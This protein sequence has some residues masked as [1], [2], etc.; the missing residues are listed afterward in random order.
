MIQ[1]IDKG[2][3]KNNEIPI[4]IYNKTTWNNFMDDLIFYKIIIIFTS[5]TC[6][7]DLDKIDS[8]YL[9]K[10]RID[11]YYYMDTSKTNRPL[12]QF[13]SIR[14]PICKFIDEDFSLFMV[15]WLRCWALEI[16]RDRVL[17]GRSFKTPCWESY[18]S[19]LLRED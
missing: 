8:S 1:K 14:C 4:E 3:E 11:E 12:Q 9:R 15:R 6:K 13:V 7:S 2:L 10:G 16:L 17:G 5:N 19:Y 18:G